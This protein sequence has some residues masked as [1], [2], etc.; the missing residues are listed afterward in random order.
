MESVS[1]R[2]VWRTGVYAEIGDRPW[3]RLPKEGSG[4]IEDVA[5]KSR[6]IRDS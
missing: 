2:A 5:G 4:G 3:A 6:Q 1:R